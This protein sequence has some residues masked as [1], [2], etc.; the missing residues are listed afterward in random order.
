MNYSFLSNVTFSL[1]VKF[2]NCSVIVF[3][4]DVVQ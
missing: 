2:S 4:S 1:D 3:S